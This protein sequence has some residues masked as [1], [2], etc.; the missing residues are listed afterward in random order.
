MTTTI[1]V[2]VLSFA[3]WVNAAALYAFNA[4]MDDGIERARIATLE[5]QRVIVT[6]PKDGPALVAVELP[7]F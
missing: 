6:A 3:F 7:V 5:P 1:R 4:A 2:M